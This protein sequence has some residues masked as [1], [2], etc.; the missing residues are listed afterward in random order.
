M[1]GK[2][3]FHPRRDD[4]PAETICA[5]YRDGV[6]ENALAQRFG[7]ER[8]VIQRILREASIPRRGRVEANRIMA[9]ARTDEQNAAN[10]AAARAQRLANLRA[11]AHDPTSRNPAVGRGYH[12]IAAALDARGIAVERQVQF[13]PYYLDLTLDGIAVELVYRQGLHVRSA[14]F[15]YLA[16]RQ[17]PTIYVLFDSEQTVAAR[18]DYIV[19]WLE[20]ARC[21][22]PAR[23]EYWV[24]RCHAE[25]GVAYTKGDQLAAIERPKYAKQPVQWTD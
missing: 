21:H 19:A 14:R 20:F 16:N 11:A 18:L 25:R 10:V 12:V 9:A 24:V 2:G 5:A 3:G 6:S 1:T 23:G 8:I 22:P 4:L 17:K 13:G 15:K 7:V